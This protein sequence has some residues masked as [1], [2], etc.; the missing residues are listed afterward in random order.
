MS[1]CDRLAAM[2]RQSGRAVLVGGPTEGAGASQQE[3]KD[4]SA[5]WVDT[6][7]FVGVSIPNAAMGVQLA[8][9]AGVTTAPA[10]QFF[11]RLAFE[12][13]PVQPDVA[14][15]TE[16]RDVLEHNAGWLAAA[17]S[18]VARARPAQEHERPDVNGTVR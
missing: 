16:R 13:R 4:Q 2:L 3:S 12:N 8:A 7:G 14:Y 1:A 6:G 11:A 5:R 18:A 17:V 10:E 15:G 9:A